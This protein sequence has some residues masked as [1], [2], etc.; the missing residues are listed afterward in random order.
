MNLNFY[1]I[2][3][4]FS[5]YDVWSSLVINSVSDGDDTFDSLKE[6]SNYHFDTTVDDLEL[7]GTN[8][9]P[10]IPVCRFK[11]QWDADVKA[12]SKLSQSSFIVKR[13]S[14]DKQLADYA[15]WGYDAEHSVA[16]R[17][18][19]KNGLTDPNDSLREDAKP[20]IKKIQKTLGILPLSVR[21]DVQKPGQCFY[22]HIDNFVG[23][24]RKANRVLPIELDQTKLV[25][26]IVFLENQGIGHHWQQGNL[27]LKWKKGDCFIWPWRDIP[28]G[29]ANFGH[30]NRPTLNITGT[31]TDKTLEF[32]KYAALQKHIQI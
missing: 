24:I 22:W 32:F 19:I 17:T 4:D 6:K 3:Y 1:Q 26:F 31:V 29:T 7:I 10:I 27:I 15:K 13:S 9:T 2:S 28:H 20:F 11:G 14:G 18:I 12:L 16:D 8:K 23:M 25:R 30:T 21:L 5:P